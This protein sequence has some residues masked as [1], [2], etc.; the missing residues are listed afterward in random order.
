MIEAQYYSSLYLFIVTILTVVAANGYSSRGLSWAQ[1]YSGSGIDIR[2]LSLFIALSI[3]IGFRPISGIYF[4]DTSNYAFYYKSIERLP[5]I[6]NPLTENKI[7]D[8]LFRWWASERLGISNLFFLTAIIYFGCTFLACRKLFN[9]NQYIAFLVFLGSFSTFSYATNGIKAGAAAAIFI[10]GISYYKNLIICIPLILISW[11]FHHS[12][13]LPVA[14]FCIAYFYKNVRFYYYVWFVC[15]LISAFHI[16][17]FQTL[18]ASM[19]EEQGDSSGVN[20]LMSTSSSEWGGKSGFRLD[21]VIYSA[22]PLLV[23]YYAIFKKNLKLSNIYKLLLSI[24]IITNSVW[25]LCMY[26]HYTNRI[27]YLSWFLYPIVLI[28]PIIKE[29]WGP[30]QYNTLSKVALGS[31]AFTLFMNLIYY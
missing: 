30:T 12:M 11:G 16:T 24:Y 6:Y 8:N 17:Y 23:G 1:R 28:Y 27:A 29:D 25:M 2:A 14:A 7:W 26:I 4:G 13:I 19:A 22:M 18:F 21:F 5:F 9:Q 15:L 20:Y 3:F 31:L 10:L